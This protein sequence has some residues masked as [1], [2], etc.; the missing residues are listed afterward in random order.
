M[1]DKYIYLVRHGKYHEEHKSKHLVG[2]LDVVGREQARRTGVRLR[3]LKIDSVTS[4]TM[5]RAIE[6]AELIKEKSLFKGEIH[7]TDLLRECLPSI[8]PAWKKTL[9]SPKATLLANRETLHKAHKKFFKKPTGKNDEHHLL[10]CHGNVIRYLIVRALAKDPHLWASMY[11]NHGSIS[12]I[13]ISKKGV[14]SLLLY[15]NV[16]FMP[17]RLKTDS[18][19]GLM[20]NFL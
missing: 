5:V 2:R 1:A 3:S 4:S 11:I 13:R 14:A 9:K 12:V 15:N 18:G 17:A 20:L 10:V 6:T 8:P 16:E 7:Q 19:K